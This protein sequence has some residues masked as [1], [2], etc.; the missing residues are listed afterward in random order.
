MKTEV[1]IKDG[2]ISLVNQDD[3]IATNYDKRYPKIPR[4]FIEDGWLNG[5]ARN[6]NIKVGV[7]KITG[8]HIEVNNKGE[9]II[10][11]DNKTVRSLRG[12]K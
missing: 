10:D 5:F 7:H 9:V 12:M 3:I 6:A 1:I 11:F 2:L 4:S 8:K